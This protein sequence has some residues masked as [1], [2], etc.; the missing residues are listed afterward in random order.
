MA[1]R[2]YFVPAAQFEADPFGIDRVGGES[3]SFPREVLVGPFLSAR[4]AC[5]AEGSG[6]EQVIRR[7]TQAWRRG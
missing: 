7:R 5:R 3:V 2:F 1:R 6:G 4:R